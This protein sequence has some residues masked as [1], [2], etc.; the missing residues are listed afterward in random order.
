MDRGDNQKANIEKLAL[1]LEVQKPAI[2]KLEPESRRQLWINRY[3]PSSHLAR[4]KIPILFVN[5]TNDKHY[6]LD[7]YSRSYRLVDP[8]L[9][10]VRIE[11]HGNHSHR[12]GWKPKEIGLFID[13]HL[14]GKF[15]LVEFGQPRANADRVVVE[16][17]AVVPLKEAKLW[18]TADDGLRS[19]RK[20]QSLDA[21]IKDGRI[22][23]PT[24]PSGTNTWIITATDERNAMMSTETQ[25][26]N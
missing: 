17:E 16:Y 9:R 11:P 2:D 13:H 23:A 12:E 5:G 20:W 1:E 22:I 25:F 14:L 7:S 26:A 24:L 4:V 15:G 21:V 6:V 19:A 3:D 10:R 18:Y 8:A